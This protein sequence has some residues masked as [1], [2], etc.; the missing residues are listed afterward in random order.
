MWPKMTI[1]ISCD[2]GQNNNNKFIEPWRSLIGPKVI[3]VPFLK[4]VA[5]YNLINEYY[6]YYCLPILRNFE[7]ADFEHCMH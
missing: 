1:I 5:K 7:S 2:C 3:P 6:Y 4:K